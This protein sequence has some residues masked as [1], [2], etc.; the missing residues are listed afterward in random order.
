MPERRARSDVPC[1]VRHKMRRAILPFP[2]P[3]VL[4]GLHGRRASLLAK[5]GAPVRLKLSASGGA[6]AQYFHSSV[7]TLEPL[8]GDLQRATP[9]RI[10]A[11]AVDPHPR[12]SGPTLP[13]CGKVCGTSACIAVPDRS[14]RPGWAPSHL[15]TLPPLILILGYAPGRSLPARRIRRIALP[16]STQKY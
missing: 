11:L 4:N 14:R 8:A 1:L 6:V 13:E 7:L 9:A 5:P 12:P 15:T 10:S 2:V 16:T 3:R